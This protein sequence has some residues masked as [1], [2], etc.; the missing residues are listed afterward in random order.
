MEAPTQT[1]VRACAL[2]RWCSPWRGGWQSGEISSAREPTRPF[3][4]LGAGRG[5][6]RGDSLFLAHSSQFPCLMEK[7]S[8]R[9][10]GPGPSGQLLMALGPLPPTVVLGTG[11]ATVQRPTQADALSLGRGTSCLQLAACVTLG[12]PHCPCFPGNGLTVFQ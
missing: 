2:P 7:P 10:G 4:P 9:E 1:G 8:R 6:M 12:G 11:L 3:H 5:E